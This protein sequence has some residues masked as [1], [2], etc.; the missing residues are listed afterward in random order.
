MSPRPECVWEC[1]DFIGS[2]VN[3]FHPSAGPGVPVAHWN[4]AT[5]LVI[6]EER[7]GGLRALGTRKSSM[8]ILK[9]LQIMKGVILQRIIN[10]SKNQLGRSGG[11]F[12]ECDSFSK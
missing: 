6:G 10:Q 4:T 9:S 3:K 1:R 8:C 11:V 12:W 7:V 2:T 5:I